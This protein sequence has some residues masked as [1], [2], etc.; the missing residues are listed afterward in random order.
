[1]KTE[2]E[3]Q[4]DFK[5]VEDET[6]ELNSNSTN[7][8]LLDFEILDSDSDSDVAEIIEELP[9]VGDFSGNPSFDSIQYQTPGTLL[10][11]QPLDPTT[12]V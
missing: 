11:V 9:G 5:D 12:V 1:L 6:M 4:L 10:G 2:V 8:A 3:V 7:T